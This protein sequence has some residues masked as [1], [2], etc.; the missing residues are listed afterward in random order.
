MPSST[1]TDFVKERI[2]LERQPYHKNHLPS[3]GYGGQACFLTHP[4]HYSGSISAKVYG[5]NVISDLE[6]IRER[7]IAELMEPPV[8]QNEIQ[9]LINTIQEDGSWPDINYEDVSRTGFEH[10]RHLSN[11]I[12]LSR[13]YKKRVSKFY[14]APQLKQAIDASLN[15]WLAH[16]FICDNW[17]WNQIGTPNL[18]LSTLL[19][20]DEALSDAQKTKAAPIVGRANLNAWGARPGGD[21]IKIAGILGKYALF[22]RD[23]DTLEEVV[24]TMASE[25]AYAKERNTPE[26]MRG[27]QTD[28]SFHHRRDRVTSTL[29]Y[30]RGYA[31]AFAEWAARVAGTKY[32][33]PEEAIQLLVEFYLDGISK[34]MVY[35]KYP[36]PGA[37]NR[38]ISR[39][40]TLQ[41][42][43]AETPLMLLQATD[44]RKE[45]LE[46][47]AKIREG[48]IAPD[49]TFN[50]FF[51]HTEYLSHQRPEYFTSVRMFSSRNHSMEQPYNGEGL[52]NHHLGDGANFISRSGEE[53]L[54]IF[55]VWDWQKIPGTTV[56]QKP[57][58]P[59][60]DEIQ[61]KGLSS[62][63]GAV[64]DGN[65]GAA[66]FDFKSPLDPLEAKKAWFMFDKEYVC[67]GA[68]I[69]SDASYPVAT[70]LNQSYLKEDVV[71][72]KTKGKSTLERGE[73]KLK[74]VHWLYHDSIAYIFPEATEIHLRNRVTSGSWYS[75]NHQADSPKEEIS[76]EV[77]TVWMNHGN[78]P[79]NESYAY[80]IVPA[81]DENTIENYLE[82]LPVEILANTEEVQAVYHKDL[83][84]SQLV[85]YQ[86][87]EI[88]L[89]E[90]I[91]LSALD[92]A[93]IMTKTNGKSV[94]KICVSDPSRK[95][96][97]IH[98]KVSSRFLSNADSCEISWHEDEGYSEVIISLPKGEYAGKSVSIENSLF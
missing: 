4:T 48:G 60:K 30:G 81:I 83:G 22:V 35:G 25:I 66:G 70:T 23:S 36:D 91:A 56:V 89:T 87:N 58:L 14:H 51:W 73:H 12:D 21:L 71:V 13:A 62:F 27:L 26:D 38:S 18:L 47:I 7:V 67:L 74:N 88:Q 59:S 68:G 94:E 96:D 69:R 75:I 17:W 53:Y 32:S 49:L 78:K 90:E 50:K 95:L 80:I 85:F 31:D 65:Y 64:T 84:L 11:M 77:F 52:K 8:N 29:S 41:A 33:F 24:K 44:Y 46:Q 28:L 93:I 54:D 79:E 97:T 39:A 34:T 20:M 15:F 9:Q 98:L 82:K 45:A 40:G 61:K 76:K 42:Y 86:P 72:K 57:A 55:P 92:P 37:K 43:D 10:A 3:L 1:Q 2:Q 19:I 63:V 5:E 6:V 16:N